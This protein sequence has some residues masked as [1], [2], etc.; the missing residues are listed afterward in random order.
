MSI[1]H[2]DYEIPEKFKQKPY[3]FVLQQGGV[4]SAT[5]GAIEPLFQQVQSHG[6]VPYHQ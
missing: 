2:L 4:I 3:E 5:K 6:A 1:F